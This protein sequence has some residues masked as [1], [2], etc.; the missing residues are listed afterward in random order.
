MAV[1]RTTKG[2]GKALSKIITK[3]RNSI[4]VDNNMQNNSN[5]KQEHQ[6]ATNVH[7]GP[8]LNLH[9]QET[10]T[11]SAMKS[12]FKGV[13]TQKTPN[14]KIHTKEGSVHMTSVQDPPREPQPSRFLK[15]SARTP[16]KRPAMRFRPYNPPPQKEPSTESTS[17]KSSKMD[18]DI[19]DIPH[20]RGFVRVFL[21]RPKVTRQ[22]RK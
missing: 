18:V 12:I 16:P 22:R 1:R 7:N 20:G 2:K 14:V 10:P 17:S 6:H 8:V 21:R 15:Q 5:N 11:P 19:V 13:A 3:V 9:F 4:N